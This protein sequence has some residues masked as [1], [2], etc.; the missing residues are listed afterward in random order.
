MAAKSFE[1]EDH[2]PSFEGRVLFIYLNAKKALLGHYIVSPHFEM[3]GGRLYLVGTTPDE[4]K[5]PN[6]PIC[7]A[8]ERV[9]VYIVADSMDA[10][11]SSQVETSDDDNEE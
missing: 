7:I 8:W 5:P 6:H 4:D 11:H 2:L 9:E 3:Q 1:L 10:F